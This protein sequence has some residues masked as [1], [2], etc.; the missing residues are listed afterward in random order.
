MVAVLAAAMVGAQGYVIDSFDVDLTLHASGKLDVTERIAVTFS[1]SRRGIYRLIPTDYDNGRGTTRSIW[2]R[3]VRVTDVAGSSLTTLVER[4]GANLKIRVGDEDIFFPPGSS[5]TYVISYNVKGAVNWDETSG[6]WGDSAELYWNLTGN[7]WDTTIGSSKFRV[8]FPN[9]EGGQRARARLL[10]GTYGARDSIEVGK[11]GDS[12]AEPAEGLAL[13]LGSDNVTGGSDQLLQIG[14]GLTVVLGLPG[15]LIVKPTWQE[16]AWMFLLSNLGFGIPIVMF[17]GMWASWMRFG[18]DPAGGPMVVQFEPPE[19]LTGPECGTLLDEKVDPRDLASGIVSLAVKGFLDVYPKEEGLIFKRI[20]ADLEVHENKP[21]NGLSPF[22][23][24]LLKRLK[25]VSG[26]ITDSELRSHV[27]PHV[28]ELRKSL[29][30]E[31]VTQRYYTMSPDSARAKWAV[32]G[33]VFV[34]ILGFVAAIINP[35]GSVL[36]SIV[37][38]ILGGIVATVFSGAMPRRTLNGSKVRQLVKG[39]EEFIRRARGNELEWMSERHPDELM[40]EEY[41]PHAVAFGLTQEWAAAFD[42]ILKEPPIWYHS[43][44]GHFNAWAFGSDFNSITDSVSS[45]ASTPPRSSGGSGGSSGFSSGGGFS[46]GGFGGGG[47]GSW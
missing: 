13:A 15:E 17:L 43:P 35:M 2:I 6:R 9:V 1:E 19:G 42:G 31:L 22:E 21:E 3:D 26:R 11:I 45:A 46:G 23:K 33:W 47:G 27:A 39:F 4:S 20:T 10:W 38:G 32:A 18:R 5:K 36:P 37:G 8:S 12:A 7:E 29:Y 44:G 14:E 16:S 30:D 34:A 41:L 40:F 28:Q 25:A 24:A